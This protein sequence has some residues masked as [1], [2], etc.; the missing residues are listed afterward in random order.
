MEVEWKFE[1]F[2]NRN[3]AY[4]RERE[5]DEWNGVAMRRTQFAAHLVVVRFNRA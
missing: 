3:S 5:I 1:L 4:L 2:V